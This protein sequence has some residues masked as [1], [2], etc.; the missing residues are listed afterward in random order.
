MA[1]GYWLE[2]RGLGLGYGVWSVLGS[3]PTAVCRHGSLLVGVRWLFGQAREW[4]VRVAGRKR[5]V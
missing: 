2:P 3:A 1:K 5:R 4:L